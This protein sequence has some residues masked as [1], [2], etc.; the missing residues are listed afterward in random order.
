MSAG[1][2]ALMQAAQT[3]ALD[4]HISFYSGEMIIAGRVAPQHWWYD[5]TKN[6]HRAVVESANRK[7][8]DERA[9]AEAVNEQTEY[10]NE[11]LT[12]VQSVEDEEAFDEVTLVDVTVLPAVTTG[13]TRP[14]GHRLPVAR[15]PLKSINTW[16]I[17]DGDEIKGSAGLSAG[18]GVLFPIGD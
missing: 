1:I 11:L 8:R 15:V 6:A 13:G 12:W 5:V 3:E 2:R 14:G 10:V 9:R 17:I 16:W 7:V 4:F 18:F